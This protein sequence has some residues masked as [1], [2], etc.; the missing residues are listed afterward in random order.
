MPTKTNSTTG[1]RNSSDAAVKEA[2]G[3]DWKQWFAALDRDGAAELDHKGIVA[4]ASKHG[5]KP[6]WQQMV[7]V[8]Y[9]QARGLRKKHETTAG[10][11]ISRSKT[12]GVPMARLYGAC[13]DAKLR[14]KWLPKA[15]LEV[16]KA[17]ANRSM[18]MR[19]LEDDSRAEFMFYG[20][21]SG[22]AQ[23]AVQHSKLANEKL[24]ARMKTYW[25]DALERLDKL[26]AD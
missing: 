2:T 25:G 18:R 8:E 13:A 21:P 5:A 3:K 7:T 9:E 16:S 23:I 14:A 17:T 11:S 12:L 15:R 10:F 20:T 4:L 6:W 24:A 26:L 1:V 19:W 22:K